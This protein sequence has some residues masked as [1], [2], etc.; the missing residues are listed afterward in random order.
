METNI[1]FWENIILS[2]REDIQ[3]R[4][5]DEETLFDIAEYFISRK[6]EKLAA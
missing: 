3:P 1:K 5:R 2:E 6:K 4:S